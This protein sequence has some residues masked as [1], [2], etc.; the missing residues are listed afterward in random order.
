MSNRSPILI[1]NGQG[2]WSD[3]I[4][5]TV[6]LVREGPLHYLTRDYLT[7]R[8]DEQCKKTLGNYYA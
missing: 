1:A 8:D 7:E 3:S 5:S 2:F 6:R 4:L